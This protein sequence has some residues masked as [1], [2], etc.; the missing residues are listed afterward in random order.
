MANLRYL[1][2]L[3]VRTVPGIVFVDIIRSTLEILP[4]LIHEPMPSVLMNARLLLML[5]SGASAIVT[6]LTGS[7]TMYAITLVALV[8]N[9]V[10]IAP[11]TLSDV[12]SPLAQIGDV[13]E[14]TYGG[15]IEVPWLGIVGLLLVLIVDSY[16]TAFRSATIKS[17]GL[18]SRDV[19]KS[20]A[21]FAVLLAPPMAASV[22]TGAYFSALIDRLR[23]LSSTLE[24]TSPRVLSGSYV[25]YIVIA[26]LSFLAIV[27][28][29]DS[30]MGAVTPFVVPSRR[31]SL[32]VLADE[33]DLDKAF[34]PP[35]VGTILGLAALMFYP[36]IHSLLFGVLV[37]LPPHIATGGLSSV[38]VHLISFLV[39]SL[40]VFG[41]V[42]R[43]IVFS[44]K[45]GIVSLTVTLSLVYASAVKMSVRRGYDLPRSLIEPDLNGV[46]EL[47][48]RSYTDYAYYLLSFMESL[49]RL[50]GVVP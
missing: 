10:P 30:V 17:P 19:A 34:S 1:L 2:L 7:V 31:L 13:A 41:S 38:V 49:F 3:A 28:L 16:T 40:V 15:G 44:H 32:R 12:F 14:V 50:L 37:E 39:T 21:A 23:S 5:I 6:V 48:G 4:R 47:I 18:A 26:S 42:G 24:P 46:L 8:L 11:L 25:T 35:L 36:A 45:R 27:K 20:V 22:A 33:A 43:T 29:M 9:R